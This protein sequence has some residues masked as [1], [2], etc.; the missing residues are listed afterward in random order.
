MLLWPFVLLPHATTVP[1]VFTARTCALA[2][3]I[4]TTPLK[5]VGNAM[6]WKVTP[7][8]TTVPSDFNAAEIRSPAAIWITLVRFAGT[9]DW[10]LALLPHATTVPL[11]RNAST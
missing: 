8:R 11:L 10:L 2:A 7:Q 6:P 4:W 5:P 1:S 9:F 3:E